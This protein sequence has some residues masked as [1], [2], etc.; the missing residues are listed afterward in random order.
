MKTYLFFALALITLFSS[1]C[2]K[3]TTTSA[4]Y[5]TLKGVKYVDAK[6]YL[7]DTNSYRLEGHQQGDSSAVAFCFIIF[8]PRY[9]YA[10]NIYSGTYPL[11][12]PSD[13]TQAHVSVGILLPGDT[14]RGY[15]STGQD[16]TNLQVSMTNGK[17]GFDVSSVKVGGVNLTITPNVAHKDTVDASIHVIQQ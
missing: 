10:H 15:Q 1:S 7:N 16:H 5:F 11:Y 13:T 17:I 6:V 4:N 9:I 3:T 8:S 12:T 2:K 14:L